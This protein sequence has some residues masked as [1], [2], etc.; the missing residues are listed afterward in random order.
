MHLNFDAAD[1]GNLNAVALHLERCGSEHQT[2]ETIATLESWEARS[3]TT[4]D[5][6]KEILK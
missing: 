4:L 2:V 1:F 6:P 3:L 5:P